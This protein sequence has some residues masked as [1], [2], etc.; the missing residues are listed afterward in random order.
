MRL[1]QK[2][3]K[4]TLTVDFDDSKLDR[5]D[6]NPSTHRDLEIVVDF[7][8]KKVGANRVEDQRLSVDR[9]GNAGDG[10]EQREV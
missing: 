8:S 10:E 1:P 2:S 6:S 5:H 4:K 7:G 9:A 3:K